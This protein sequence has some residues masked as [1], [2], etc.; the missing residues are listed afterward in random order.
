MAKLLRIF[1][2]SVILSRL[3]QSKPIYTA[4]SLDKQKL[5][6]RQLGELGQ[7]LPGLIGAGIGNAV[8]PGIGGIV[9]GIV[10]PI[11]ENI[12]SSAVDN[13]MANLKEEESFSRDAPVP[14]DSYVVNIPKLGP[15]V[16]LVPKVHEIPQEGHGIDLHSVDHHSIDPHHGLSN[17]EESSEVKDQTTL[18]DKTKLHSL[19]PSIRSSNHV[20]VM[21]YRPLN[22]MKTKRQSGPKQVKL[23]H[24]TQN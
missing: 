1:V 10:G 5:E 15:Y 24:P 9:G 19:M 6:N 2:L 8:T 11:V 4:K 3:V 22:F 17:N 16:I 7:V 20:R 21:P 13:L 23:F 12:V 18:Q 14:Y